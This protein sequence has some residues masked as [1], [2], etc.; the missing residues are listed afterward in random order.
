MSKLCWVLESRIIIVCAHVCALAHSSSAMSHVHIIEKIIG[1]ILLKFLVY[2]YF[3]I[4]VTKFVSVLF[5][6]SVHLFNFKGNYYSSLEFI[7]VQKSLS[8]PQRA[9]ERKKWDM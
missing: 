1:A 8:G 4:V 6:P 7:T 3:V 9:Q 2:S 5:M